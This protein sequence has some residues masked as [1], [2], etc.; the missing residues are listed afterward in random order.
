MSD[1]TK[2]I[3][4]D[5]LNGSLSPN[6]IRFS[7]PIAAST[8]LQ[9]LFNSADVAVVGRFAGS[10]ALAAVGANVANV[11]VFVNLIVGLA[12]GPNVV[13]SMLI[14]QG[15]LKEVNKVVHNIITFAIVLGLGLMA[16]GMLL[17]RPI[18][19]LTSTPDNILDAAWKYLMIYLAGIP[20]IML[21]NFGSSILRSIGDSK[22]PL[23]ALLVGGIVNVILN[24]FFVIV[25]HMQVTGVAL[26]TVLSNVLSAGIVL[27][28]IMH[29][30]EVIRFSFSKIRLDSQILKRILIIGVPS[31]IQYMIFSV[32]NI[33]IQAGINSFG[34]D[35]IAGSVAALNFEYFTYAIAAAFAQATITFTSQNYGARKYDRCSKVFWLTLLYGA[36]FTGILAGIFSLWRRT[37]IGIYTT[38]EAVIAYG[39]IRMTHV[40]TYEAITAFTDVPAAALRGIGYSVAPAVI[41]VI[42]TVGFRLVWMVTIF[43]MFPTFEVLM[44]VYPISWVVIGTTTAVL[45]LILRRRKFV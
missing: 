4:M 16:L 44:D 26:A 31:G 35:A 1:N 23:Y 28:I 37:F 13:M 29:E 12:I 17:A 33:F 2:A 8:I 19:V 40:V 15:R 6:L 24:L 30:S 43:K 11:G 10:E 38:D 5:M 20:F 42:G 21:Y 45:Y 27:F 25:L 39:I 41:S 22:R 34:N 9:Q 7:L 32:S 3:K 18:L 14:G 36:L